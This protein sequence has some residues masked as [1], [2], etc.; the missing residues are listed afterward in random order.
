[1]A[2]PIGES[3]SVDQATASLFLLHGVRAFSVRGRRSSGYAAGMTNIDSSGAVT[4]PPTM[5]AAMVK[6]RLRRRGIS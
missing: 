1:M 5:G 3:L 2:I 6:R 4:I